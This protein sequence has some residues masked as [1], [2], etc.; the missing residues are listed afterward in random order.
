MALLDGEY[1]EKQP[2]GPSVILF[3]GNG[4]TYEDWHGLEFFTDRNINI[5]AFS[6]RGYGNSQGTTDEIAYSSALDIEASLRFL[7]QNKNVPQENIM[8]YGASLGGG[9]ATYAARYF[10]IPT[11][12]SNTFTRIG[13]I[14]RIMLSGYHQQ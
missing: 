9:Y 11:V 8:S 13:D 4:M 6:F 14:M 5:L 3:H 2:R 10:G 7:I 12:L 1:I